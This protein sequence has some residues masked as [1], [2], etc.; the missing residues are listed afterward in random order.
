MRN[1]QTE[2]EALHEVA[3]LDPTPGRI[4]LV[5]IGV[6]EEI[7]RP[8]IVVDPCPDSSSIEVAPFFADGDAPL[9]AAIRL[10]HTASWAVTMHTDAAIDD[11]APGCG[12]WIWPR[13][14]AT[15]QFKCESCD[16]VTTTGLC[17]CPDPK[18]V[19]LG[20]SV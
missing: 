17:G 12:E 2:G 9:P 13:R 6:G 18:P 4:V 8:A 15:A 16:R 3:P 10:N 14:E 20:P 11:E 5:N 19:G 7:L 1:A